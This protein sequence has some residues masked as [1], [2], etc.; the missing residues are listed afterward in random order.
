M[1]YS[2][3]LI[4]LQ[5]M[6]RCLSSLK[7][8]LQSEEITVSDYLKLSDFFTEVGRLQVVIDGLQLVLNVDDSSGGDYA[9]HLT[10]EKR[11]PSPSWNSNSGH[12]DRRCIPSTFID[13]DGTRVPLVKSLK[14]DF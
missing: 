13:P 11:S 8:F 7:V 2:S 12:S 9:H 5:D 6:A 1:S 4:T 3:N 14:G 10:V